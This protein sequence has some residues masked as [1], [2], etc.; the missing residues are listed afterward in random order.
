MRIATWNLER[1][2][3]NGKKNTDIIDILR[4]LDAD[5]VVL[6]E[7]NECIQF[8]DAMSYYLTDEL[9]NPMY[10]PGERRVI[11]CTRYEVAVHYDTYDPATSLCIELRTPLGLLAVYGTIIGVNGNRDKSFLPDLRKQVNDYNEISQEVSLCIAGDLNT[12]FNDN[13][14]YTKEGRNQLN[15]TFN[16]LGMQN[17]TTSI[18]NNIDHILISETFIDGYRCTAKVFAD[19]KSLSDHK[20]VVV[21]IAEA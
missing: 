3:N 12:S 14:Y 16:Q 4:K 10:K 21:E 18:A 20:G 1:P 11:I 6:T 2:V 19:D 9:T 7:A 17:L 13:F 5:I 15:D 8:D